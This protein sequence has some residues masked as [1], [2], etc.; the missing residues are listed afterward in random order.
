LSRTSDLIGHAL[1]RNL[2]FDSCMYAIDVR[3]LC[4]K[5]F[6][7]RAPC[8]DTHI[9]AC[10]RR[11]EKTSNTEMASKHKCIQRSGLKKSL[12][13]RLDQFS[14]FALR[15]MHLP[16][17]FLALLIAISHTSTASTFLAL[18]A[19]I[20]AVRASGQLEHSL[21]QTRMQ[22]MRIP[23]LLI[24]IHLPMLRPI[25]QALHQILQPIR[26]NLL[27][28]LPSLIYPYLV[29]PGEDRVPLR[30]R[31]CIMRVDELPSGSGRGLDDR[32]PDGSG[33]P[34]GE[35]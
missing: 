18:G 4:T 34:F 5:N 33:E 14:G 10:I 26:R 16:V 17:Q 6:C 8:V 32:R 9:I 24:R 31:F 25:T 35:P 20:T 12:C 19:G 11:R 27:C 1:C 15:L 28:V 13:A 7:F 2:Y 3:I 22:H 29:P 21:I 23:A 30:R